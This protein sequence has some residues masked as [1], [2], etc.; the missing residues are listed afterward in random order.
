MKRQ[1]DKEKFV[2]LKAEGY[3]NASISRELGIAKATCTSW[4]RELASQ[5]ED[6]KKTQLA[7]LIEGYGIAKEARIKRLGETLDKIDSAVEQLDFTL[8]AP[9]KLLDLQIAYTNALKEEYNSLRPAGELKADTPQGIIEALIN[10]LD[11]ARA[12]EVTK[13]QAT[14]ESTIIINLLRAIDIVEV[15]A[16]IDELERIIDNAKN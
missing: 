11:R 9:A 13:E 10:L 16:K 3:S 14:S 2:K 5:I 12:G 15:K 4:G 1:K 6:A 8:I 7:E